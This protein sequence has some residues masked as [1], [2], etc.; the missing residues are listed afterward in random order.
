MAYG[1]LNIIF[2]VFSI[3]FAFFALMFYFVSLSSYSTAYLSGNI[4][5]ASLSLTLSF[6]I[7]LM[8]G[9]IAISYANYIKSVLNGTNPIV[10]ANVPYS[11]PVATNP[12]AFAQYPQQNYNTPVNNNPYNNSAYE[13]PYANPQ[14][15]NPQ[16]PQSPIPDN[17]YNQ[18]QQTV[19][20]NPY[21]QIG[22][23]SCRERV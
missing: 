19:E 6:V 18:Y 21:Q 22:R 20:Q 17:S 13:N 11:N 16:E 7:Y 14:Q 4:L 1:V 9:I 10:N 2:A 15:I 12:N 8:Q 23:A 5:S 3:I